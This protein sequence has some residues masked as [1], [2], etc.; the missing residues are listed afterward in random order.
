MLITVNDIRKHRDI[1]T[2][3]K[4]ER[5]DEYIQ[6]AEASDIR[7][8]LGDELFTSLTSDPTD[9]TQGSY[10]ALLDG[11]EYTFNG[12]TYRHPGL[13]SVLSDFAYARY[14]FFGSEVDTPF[15]TVQKTF[16]QSVRP[17]RTRMREVYSAIRKVAKDKWN[18][19]R[20]YLDRS[21]AT[22]GS[23]YDLWFGSEFYPD[24]DQDLI[25]INKG[26]LR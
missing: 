26:T 6:D 9:T 21:N 12:Y 17:S 4:K 7:P 10:P 16:D 25:N 14:K 22:V 3:V 2:S 20:L 15:S 13:K 18:Q 5:V 19:V 24:D 11:G 1:S 8:L 23:E